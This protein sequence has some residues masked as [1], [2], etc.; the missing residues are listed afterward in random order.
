M[1]GHIE[2]VNIVRFDHVAQ[3]VDDPVLVTGGGFEGLPPEDVL[4]VEERH[5]DPTDITTTGV[6]WDSPTLGHDYGS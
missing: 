5:D 4:E 6:T 2:W 1:G 3:G